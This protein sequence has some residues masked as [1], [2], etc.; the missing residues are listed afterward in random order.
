M[1]SSRLS[2][3]KSRPKSGRLPPKFY[4]KKKKKVEKVE[5]K[6]KKKKNSKIKKLK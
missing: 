3:T 5:K 2:K 1:L 6:K 4:L